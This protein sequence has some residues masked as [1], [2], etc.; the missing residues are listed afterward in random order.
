MP[1]G[2]S[3]ETTGNYAY[4]LTLYRLADMQRDYLQIYRLVRKHLKTMVALFIISLAVFAY[5]V[6][7]LLKPEQF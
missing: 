5:M 4:A 7:V 6:Y 3:A 2:Y 1:F